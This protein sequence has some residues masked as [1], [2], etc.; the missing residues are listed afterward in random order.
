MSLYLDIE[1]NYA[2]EITVL[3]F[4][5]RGT[6]MVQLVRPEISPEAVL[7]ALPARGR[8]F[9]Y[10]GHCFDLPVI[11]SRLGVDLRKQYESVDLRFVCQ[12]VGWRGGLKKVEERLGIPRQLPGLDGWAALRLW[13]EY[14]IENDKRALA[15]LLQY[16]RDDVMNLVQVHKALKNHGVL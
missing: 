1:T 2:G 12:R 15:I 16:N 6:G 10:N 8:L 13:E 7:D 5:S 9:T 11:R 3:G 14:W 4:Y